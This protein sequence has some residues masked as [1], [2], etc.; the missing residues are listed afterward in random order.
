MKLRRIKPMEV[1]PTDPNEACANLWC[2]CY[3][4]KS[5]L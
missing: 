1:Q 5:I 4:E 2:A 3:P